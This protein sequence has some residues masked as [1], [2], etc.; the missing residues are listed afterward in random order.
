MSICSRI[1]GSAGFSLQSRGRLKLALPGALL[2]VSSAL[3]AA[4]PWVVPATPEPVEISGSGFIEADPEHLQAITCD[5]VGSRIR[6]LGS[7]GQLVS[8]G[9]VLVELDTS[10]ISER[11][12]ERRLQSAEGDAQFALDSLQQA[13]DVRSLEDERGD[14]RVRLIAVRARLA[15]L[16]SDD[17]TL[18]A[19]AQA[20]AD[21]AAAAAQAAR[22]QATSTAQLAAL[23]DVAEEDARAATRQAERASASAS[24]SALA[25]RAAATVD[26]GPDRERLLIEE[27]DVV[28]RLALAPDGTEDPK[29]GIG[30]RLAA[31]LG[32][33]ESQ[34][35]NGAAE[36]DARRRELHE[37]ERDERDRTP[38]AWIEVM[39]DGAVAARYDQVAV[40]QTPADGWVADD[41]A[42]F[43]PGRGFGWDVAQTTVPGASAGGAAPGAVLVAGRATWSAQLADGPCTVRLG[44]G[45]A[46]DW[47]GALVRF[48]DGSAWTSNRLVAGIQVVERAVQ[49]Q[50]GRLVLEFGDGLVKALRAESAAMVL[51]IPTMPLGNRIDNKTQPVVW[52]IDPARMRLNV[53]LT[54]DL[55]ALVA[56]PGD[57]P[58]PRDP[59]GRTRHAMRV[60][61]LDFAASDGGRGRATVARVVDKPVDARRTAWGWAESDADDLRGLVWREVHLTPGSGAGLRP[62]TDVEVTATATATTGTTVLPAHL[63]SPRPDG[64]LVQEAGQAPRRVPALRAGSRWIVLS[65]VVAGA[66]LVPPVGAATVDPLKGPFSGEVIAGTS[67]P[68]VLS[69]AWGRIKTLVADGSDVAAG[70]VIATLYNPGLEQ[71]RE[72]LVREKA[73]AR[74]DARIS[75]ENSRTHVI[76]TADARRQRL[77]AARRARLDLDAARRGDPVAAAM[78][79]A[80]AQAAQAEAAWT[81]GLAGRLGSLSSPE[82]GR[83]ASVQA[84]SALRAVTAE[85]GVLEAARSS[86]AVDLVGLLGAEATWSAAAR[87]LDLGDGDDRLARDDTQRNRLQARLR[88]RESLRGSWFEREFEAI[89]QVRAPVAGRVWLKNGWDEGRG[90]WGRLVVDATVWQGVD[91]AEIVDPLRPA[92]RAELPEEVYPRLSEGSTVRLAFPHL[93]GLTL[94]GLVTQRSPLLGISRD[95]RSGDEVRVGAV[96][97]VFTATITFQVPDGLGDAFDPGQTGTVELE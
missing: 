45:E 33:S 79:A 82:P 81:V 53:R 68:V 91:L 29:R 23:G 50:G 64:F 94:A 60:S 92:F 90:R 36:R 25:A 1:P 61:A 26:R 6:W 32:R 88:L 48:P 77:D 2:L 86:R 59:A 95:D 49:V 27:H 51:L 96:R 34:R 85:R 54:Q 41:G 78:A 93:G 11:V 19:L 22:R 40:G 10:R 20:T 47:T 89:R 30:G 39:R 52:T 7:D 55:A 8:P 9:D 31:A 44:I 69:R 18:S 13:A 16:G 28:A 66:R 76:N 57:Q 67:T 62:R 63:V 12:A 65:G 75:A 74:Q 38:V 70:A 80:E 3:A 5:A 15:A 87:A 42:A 58:P 56:L 24:R 46:Q 4:E 73:R 17:A 72:R 35:K 37:A 14:L 84:E 43:D 83:L 21:E 97:R 71:N